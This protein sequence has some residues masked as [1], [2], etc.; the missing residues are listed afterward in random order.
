[1]AANDEMGRAA[2][3]MHEQNAIMKSADW[4]FRVEPMHDDL[5]RDVRP[6]I[7]ALMGAVTFVLLIACANVANLQLVRASAREREMAVRAAMG[8][9]PWRIVRQLVIESLVMSTVGALLAIAL[10]FGGIKLLV[11]L[12]PANLPRLDSIS[13]D[14]AV[15]GFA[16][17]AAVIA[18]GLFG[19]VPAI[20]ASKPELADVLRSSGRAPGLGGAVVRTPRRCRVDGPQ[21][22]RADA[23][24]SGLRCAWRADVPGRTA[25][26]P[27]AR[28]NRGIPAPAW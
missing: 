19:V 12:A 27:I 4:R 28:R 7:F 2:A 24:P 21:F 11:A 10:A 9:S 18:A 5:V 14:L 3:A 22:R 20:R 23:S 15:L 16:T 13:I 25:R 26:R 17:L 8:S 1:M 6:A